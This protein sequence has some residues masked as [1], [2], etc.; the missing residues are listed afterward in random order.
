VVEHYPVRDRRAR[1]E[2]GLLTQRPAH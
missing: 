1:P 2:P